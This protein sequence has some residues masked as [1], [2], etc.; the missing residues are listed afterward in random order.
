MHARAHVT[1]I[2]QDGRH[3]VTGELGRQRPGQQLQRRLACPVGTPTWIGAVRGVARDVHDEPASFGQQRH[4]QLNQGNRRPDVDAKDAPE[5]H[6][7]E[8][9][10]RADTP[11]L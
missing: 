4:R 11:E 8:T 3:A 9:R 1:G 10:E 5:S 2:N 6:D 7:V